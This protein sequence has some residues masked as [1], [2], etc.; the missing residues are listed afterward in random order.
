MQL[1][2]HAKASTAKD[3]T[4]L[5]QVDSNETTINAKDDAQTRGLSQVE[6]IICNSQG[7]IVLCFLL[8]CFGCY[9]DGRVIFCLL[10]DVNYAFILLCGRFTILLV[11]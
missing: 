5:M 9:Q 2:V 8:L 1:V 6:S 10:I 7:A 11:S 4:M 3:S